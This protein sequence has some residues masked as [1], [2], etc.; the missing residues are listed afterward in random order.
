M[1]LRSKMTEFL[2]PWRQDCERITQRQVEWPAEENT[3]RPVPLLP[4]RNFEQ[5]RGASL[6]S[7]NRVV[8]IGRMAEQVSPVPCEQ[9]TKVR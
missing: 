3:R 6:S 7:V 2:P 5:N 8:H 9:E 1:I 4:S